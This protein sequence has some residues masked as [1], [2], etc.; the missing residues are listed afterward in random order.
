ML[1]KRREFW[2]GGMAV[3]ALGVIMALTGF[4]LH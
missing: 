2:F 4:V 1:T 3:A